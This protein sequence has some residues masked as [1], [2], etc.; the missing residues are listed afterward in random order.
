MD[1]L[2]PCTT[3]NPV[4]LTLDE[5]GTTVEWDIRIIEHVLDTTTSK[6]HE[7]DLGMYKNMFEFVSLLSDI[8]NTPHNETIGAS[9]HKDI[10]EMNVL[11]FSHY[12]RTLT[13]QTQKLAAIVMYL[14]YHAL[15]QSHIQ[16][17]MH[18]DGAILDDFEVGLLVQAVLGND[19]L[20]MYSSKKGVEMDAKNHAGIEND[21]WNN[22]FE[23]WHNDHTDHFEEWHNDHTDHFEEWHEDK[24]KDA[25]VGKGWD[26]EFSEIEETSRSP[27]SNGGMITGNG[28]GNEPTKVVADKG[29][30]I[31]FSE[32]EDEVLESPNIQAQTNDLQETIE[33][34]LEPIV[35]TTE[36]ATVR[37]KGWDVEF[38]EMKA[39]TLDSP[40]IQT[41]E[42]DIQEERMV[43][44]YEPL[45]VLPTTN[46]DVILDDKGWDVELSELEHDES[47]PVSPDSNESAGYNNPEPITE[48]N[49]HQYADDSDALQQFDTINYDN[50]ENEQETEPNEQKHPMID[51]DV[52]IEESEN[53]EL[54][55]G[56]GNYE[57]ISQPNVQNIV[58]DVD[59]QELPVIDYGWNVNI[60]ESES[61][62]FATESNNGNVITDS[63]D[64][65]DTNVHD[66]VDL[67]LDVAEYEWNM[68]T[69]EYETK[70]LVTQTVAL[71]DMKELSLPQLEIME[72]VDD[73]VI[74]SDS[75][76]VKGDA[77]D[78]EPQVQEFGL[79]SVS[80]PA[81]AVEIENFE[82]PAVRHENVTNQDQPEHETDKGWD[83]EI[84]DTEWIDDTRTQENPE[85]YE[86]T[87]H[88]ED[89]NH[90]V[91]KYDAEEFPA[92]IQ[93]QIDD[94]LPYEWNY[95]SAL[96][97]DVQLAVD[98]HLIQPY[99][100]TFEETTNQ[101][102]VPWDA[103]ASV[104]PDI[105]SV[106]DQKIFPEPAIDSLHPDAPYVADSY[107]EAE[108]E[109][110]KGWDVVF[111]I[112][113]GR[114][115]TKNIR[116]KKKGEISRRISIMRIT[117]K[118][119]LMI[120]MKHI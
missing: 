61:E 77:Y 53:E 55:T 19:V 65:P 80:M 78:N 56:S 44:H 104:S 60:N 79:E 33:E 82:D 17:G 103:E 68:N 109:T 10:H 113:S 86:D 102:T 40:N 13:T 22:E 119:I 48:S 42:G 81:N 112:L 52:N 43:E 31:D 96:D 34:Y 110:E 21:K 24:N 107:Q 97:V 37:D 62:D 99:T 91:K 49:D 2:T 69:R 108:P 50:G 1:I 106:S 66:G 6:P 12:L 115:K 101:I 8:Q 15:S 30:D 93:T 57:P 5:Y 16:M 26:V 76:N 100:D 75:K 11:Q 67:Q 120:N 14:H 95:Q 54:V 58:D 98:D 74:E 64:L 32:M 71:D 72:D 35:P 38:S 46:E 47:G 27:D 59:Q 63:R 94:Q 7:R 70:E 3:T 88:V 111:Q 85:E 29:W 84:S 41:Q 45:P 20:P 9:I 23:E 36:D 89:I 28:V 73:N 39:E 105:E 18:S 118:T 51:Y 117:R 92:A 90:D 114:I 116:M 87:A 83:V 4:D 25:T